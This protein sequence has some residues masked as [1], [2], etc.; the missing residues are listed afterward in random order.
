MLQSCAAMEERQKI[1]K[2]EKRGRL[3]Q[4]KRQLVVYSL[5]PGPL[6]T[7]EMKGSVD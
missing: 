3:L 2:K 6:W 5:R 4:D 1:V 7:W